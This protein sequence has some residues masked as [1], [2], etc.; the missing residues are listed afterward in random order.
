[1]VINNPQQL[2]SAMERAVRRMLDSAS[3]EILEEFK[4]EY[5]QKY[6]YDSHGKN[7]VYQNPNGQEFKESWEWTGIQ[8]LS[9]ELVTTM[10][11]NYSKM[12]TNPGAFG[13]VGIHGSNVEGWSP[14]ER[15]YLAET[16]DK[17][18]YSSSLWVSVKRPVAYWQK[19]IQ[20]MFNAG[21][22]QKILEKHARANG[23]VPV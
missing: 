20:D 22:L 3:K 9:D 2:Q 10:W 17:T 1:M 18:G 23:L 7:K 5:I 19:F 8:K 11:Y 16:L 13:L 15:P 6:V 14:D 4:E 21:K 12:S